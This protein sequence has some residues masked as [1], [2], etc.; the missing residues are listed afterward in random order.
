MSL[1]SPC[2]REQFAGLYKLKLQGRRQ[3]WEIPH[4]LKK[5]GAAGWLET[6]HACGRPLA[7]TSHLPRVA[8]I[9]TH[10][11]LLR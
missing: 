4:E 11:P 10:P 9:Y 5:E 2:L 6:S 7:P 1:L 8:R 3:R